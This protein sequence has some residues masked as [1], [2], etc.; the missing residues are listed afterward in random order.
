MGGDPGTRPVGLRNKPPGGAMANKL[1]VKSRPG[2]GSP[3]KA[4][5]DLEVS[6]NRSGR[7]GQLL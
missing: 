2:G 7:C 5:G 6:G 4:Q 1:S 3:E